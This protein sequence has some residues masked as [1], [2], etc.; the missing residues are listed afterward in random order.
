MS[1]LYFIVNECSKLYQDYFEYLE[2]KEKVR[3]IFLG[4]KEK[5]GIEASGF[6]P[7]KDRFRIAA[8]RNDLSRFASRLKKTEP[9]VF[10][11]NSPMH[12]EWCSLVADIKHM[13]KPRL[14]FYIQIPGYRWSE[15][16]FN[17]NGTLYGMI[18][19]NEEFNNDF[20]LPDFMQEIKASEFYKAIE[21]EEERVKENG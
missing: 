6:Y 9:G 15:T 5:Y 13:E 12:K 1:E 16:L 18:R 4:I 17:I 2:D 14:V 20:K 21:E 8:T 19:S 7:N 11:K 10:K 3:K